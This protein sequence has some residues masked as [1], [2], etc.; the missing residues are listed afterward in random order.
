MMPTPR[1]VCFGLVF[2]VLDLTAPFA[3]AATVQDYISSAPFKMPAVPVPS[4]PERNFSIV[5]FDAVGDGHT[6]NTAA[7]TKA[8]EACAQAGGGHVVVPA[9][10]WLTGPI[11]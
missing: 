1:T 10:M 5:D 8:I 9:G 2:S 4:F 11:V 6:L 3:G 7:F